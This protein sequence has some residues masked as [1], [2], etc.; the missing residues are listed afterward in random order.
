MLT[1]PETIPAPTAT[2]LS[3]Q[4]R[5]LQKRIGT[6]RDALD[7][8][9]DRAAE[10]STLNGISHALDKLAMQAQ[11]LE[12]RTRE[13]RNKSLGERLAALEFRVREGAATYGGYRAKV[14]GLTASGARALCAIEVQ[15][16]MTCGIPRTQKQDVMVDVADLIE[17]E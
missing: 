1:L 15:I 9:A 14:L 6:V 7:G 16:G 10:T 11:G 3:G 2:T 8:F 13:Y 4:L 12:L 5:E 17:L